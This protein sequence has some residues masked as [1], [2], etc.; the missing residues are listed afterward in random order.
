M[1]YLTN[2]PN[3]P[4]SVDGISEQDIENFRVILKCAFGVEISKEEAQKQARDLFTLVKAIAGI[5]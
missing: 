3:G 2:R 1:P 4:S 5:K